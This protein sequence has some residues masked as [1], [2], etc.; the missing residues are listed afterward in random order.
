MSSTDQTEGQFQ[1]HEPFDAVELAT[2]AEQFDLD[3]A[4]AAEETGEPQATAPAADTESLLQR[5]L[6]VAGSDAA[7]YLPVRFVPALTS[8]ITTPLFTRA[9]D[10]EDYGAFYLVSSIC[11]LLASIAVGWLQS[12]SIRFY[13]PAKKD[14][15]LDGYVST[16][17]WTGLASLAATAAVSAAAAWLARGSIEAVVWRLIPVAIAYFIANFYT[18]AMLQ[19]LRA[20][21]RA[22][23][24]ARLMIATTVLVTIASVAL[25]WYARWG[26]LGIL[27]G[28]AAGNLA[29]APFILRDL[30]REGSLSPS[31]I[32]RSQLREMLVYGM[33]LVPAGL[34]SWA[35]IV[36]DRFVLQAL[37][38]A[39]E[40]GVYSVAY[41]LGDKIMQ[42]VTMPLLLTMMPSLIEAYEKH[43]Q[44]LAE[45]VQTQFTRYF[46][47]L[48]VPLLAGLGAAS[49][50]F[51]FV[52]TGPQY[53][54]A[55]A[56]LAIVAGGSMLG[57]F[58]QVAGAGLGIHKK[59]TLIMANTIV[60]ALFNVGLNFTL[61][62]R[63]GYAAAAWD[64][65]ASYL[66]LL[67][68]TWLQSR[69]YMRWMI[70]WGD[71]T[72]IV[73][74][75][76]IMAACVWA[77]GAYL[78]H[79]V[80]L[81]GAQVLL[82]IVVYVAALLLLGGVRPQERAFLGQLARTGAARLTG[83]GR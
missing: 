21:K 8:L 29:V 45:K 48:T 19:V 71:L 70:P 37:R 55:Y 49:Q 80:L 42:L 58:A 34:A 74:A 35:L 1:D 60:A 64:T 81:L 20:A 31:G 66:L 76:A 61:I 32:D 7:K 54:E 50:V 68:A 75:S 15:R 43:G 36:L 72:R 11:S 12:S 82:G 3:E 53:R 77:L 2:E 51:M 23:A 40:V 63:F 46:A 44:P 38:G 73:A 13:W 79:G 9:I 69:R 26:A 39:A 33:P 14:G 41:T 52:F 65:L 16:I 30:A 67:V 18:T 78:Q 17:V 56:V 22:S 4:R 83:R 59:T 5:A 47:I 28:A 57:S 25:V 10:K 27:A 62:P 6:K 24:Y